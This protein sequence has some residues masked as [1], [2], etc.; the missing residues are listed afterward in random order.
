M[1]RGLHHYFSSAD[2]SFPKDKP[3]HSEFRVKRPLDDSNLDWLLVSVLHTKG[4]T[5]RRNQD[6]RS[7]HHIRFNSLAK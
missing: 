7:I 4:E 2:T 6:L 1:K 5:L 3:D